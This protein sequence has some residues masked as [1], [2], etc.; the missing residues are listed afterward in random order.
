MTSRHAAAAVLALAMLTGGPVAA[1]ERPVDLE[2]VLAVDGSASV[3]YVEFNLQMT[4]IARAFRDE[5]VVAAVGKGPF[6]TV[7]VTLMVWSGNET[8][9]ADI[10][11]FEVSDRTSCWRFATAVERMVRPIQPGATA[12]NNAIKS[13]LDRLNGNRYGGVRRVIDISSDGKENALTDFLSATDI[14]R[15]LAIADGV[16]VNGL[17][18]LTDEPDLER[19]F[20]EN[21]V[22]GPDAFLIPARSYEDFAEAMRRKL[23]REISGEPLIGMAPPEN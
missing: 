3:D 8:P 7:V 11:W 16:T 15:S 19:Y 23:L 10:G 18:I 22:G 2:L 12:I 17:P 5:E 4:G 1:Q 9:V 20:R 13:A 21:I 6:H 14:G